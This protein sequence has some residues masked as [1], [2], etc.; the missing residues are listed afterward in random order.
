MGSDGNCYGTTY[1]GS[2]GTIFRV[3]TNGTLTTLVSFNGANG[4]NPKAALIQAN[5]GSFYGTTY[6]GGNGGVGVIYRFGFPP[7][8]PFIIAQPTS[9]AVTNGGSANFNVSV[10]GPLPW[11]YQWFT[12]SGRTATAVPFMSGFQVQFAIITS[13]GSGYSSAPL[14]QF[15]GSGTRTASGTAV[16]S[17]GMVTAINLTSHGW[18]FGLPPTVQID[19]P[20]PTISQLLPDQTNATLALATVMSADATNYFVV[21]TNN[22]GSVTSVMAGLSV[23][24]PPQSFTAQYLGTGLQLQLTGT[25]NYPYQLQSATNLA[26]PITWR[27]V[28]IQPADANGNWQFTDT[29]LSL[30]QKF[31]RV[32]GQ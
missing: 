5:D 7:I 6:E 25:P 26:P 14:V 30:V 22:Y 16:I 9:I 19:N 31:Y 13:G 3:T 2:Q 23:F 32:V 4:A 1:G 20:A 24:L 8:A 29:N 18:Y 17:N 21:V 11:S 12:S 10:S 27:T 15:I 28:L